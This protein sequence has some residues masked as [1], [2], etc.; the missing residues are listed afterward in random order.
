MSETSSRK[1]A[2]LSTRRT[3]P[4][5]G[6]CSATSLFDHGDTPLS[7]WA[8]DGT[9]AAPSSRRRSSTGAGAL[10]TTKTSSGAAFAHLSHESARSSVCSW[11]RASRRTA[12]RRER[13]GF[14]RRPMTAQC[15]ARARTG[16]RR[17]PRSGSLWAWSR[18]SRQASAR[19]GR[20]PCSMTLKL[21]LAAIGRPLNVGTRSAGDMVIPI[22][23]AMRRMVVSVS[24]TRASYRTTT[25]R[26]GCRP[27]A[28]RAAMA[29]RRHSP[30]APSTSSLPLR[31]ARND[32]TSRR[33]SV[34]W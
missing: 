32:G 14:S 26:S 2:S 28:S 4:S 25:T 1:H 27:C 7:G 21:E 6:S 29:D 8:G 20:T 19:S 5:L 3:G 30:S 23:S 12:L 15:P 22:R 24:R 9:T 18:L 34:R 11:N 16:R 33:D 13:C 10:P 31:S 17:G